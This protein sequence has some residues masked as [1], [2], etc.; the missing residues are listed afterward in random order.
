[1]TNLQIY[2][3][4]GPY[5]FVKSPAFDTYVYYLFHLNGDLKINFAPLTYGGSDVSKLTVGEKI[6]II[7]SPTLKLL[8]S[9]Q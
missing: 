4:A 1:M 6:I 2:Q 7:S 3:K 8:V 5:I 9:F